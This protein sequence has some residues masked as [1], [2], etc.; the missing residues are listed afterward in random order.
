MTPIYL[1]YDLKY[2]NNSFICVVSFCKA[3]PK[4]LKYLN[5]DTI[6]MP[7]YWIQCMQKSLYINIT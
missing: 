1:T 6:S 3:P 2:K 7:R 5:V 4:D